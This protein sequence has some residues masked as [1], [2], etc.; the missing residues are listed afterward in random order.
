M[1]LFMKMLI[2]SENTYSMLRIFDMSKQKSNG[3]KVI[4]NIKK[5]QNTQKRSVE[6][7]DNE[8]VKADTVYDPNT[9]AH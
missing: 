8:A 9:G 7:E 4:H 2:Q 3:G 5:E 6:H 1:Y